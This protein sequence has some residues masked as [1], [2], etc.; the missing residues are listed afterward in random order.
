MDIRAARPEDLPRITEIYNHE[1]QYSTATYE[2]LPHSVAQRTEWWQRLGAG[3]YPSLVIEDGQGV[4]GYAT[5]EP[6]NARPGYRY[7]VFTSVYLD[8]TIR[9]KGWGGRML[10][11]L[12]AAA[13]LR[14]FHALVA[15]IDSENEISI[16]LHER[17][18]F[19]KVAH[20]VEVGHK[21]GRWL[22]V[23]YLQLNL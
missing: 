5:L 15:S 8:P 18:G 23:I 19:K 13:K 12:I 21:F 16:T 9:G 3:G 10:D 4:Q 11:E 22:D 17:R 14:G 6:F 7:T 1:V 20:L 2:T